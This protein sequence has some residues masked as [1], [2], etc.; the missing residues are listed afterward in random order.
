MFWSRSE[1]REQGKRAGHLA[2]T[3]SFWKLYDGSTE[4]IREKVE[5][6][7]WSERKGQWWLR[8]MQFPHYLRGL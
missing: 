3:F 1:G 5:G 4:Y 8:W 2:N 7:I 6:R